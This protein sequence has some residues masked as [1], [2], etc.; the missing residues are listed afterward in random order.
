MCVDPVGFSPLS[1]PSRR[2]MRL[3][4]TLPRRGG[5]CSESRRSP[6]PLGGTGPAARGAA[7]PPAASP[8]WKDPH[9]QQSAPAPTADRVS[10]AL[11]LRLRRRRG[12]G[13]VGS[14]PSRL[15]LSRCGAQRPHPR[16]EGGERRLGVM[17]A[18]NCRSPK[19]DDTN[20]RSPAVCR[21][22]AREGASG[23]RCESR[24][25][26]IRIPPQQADPAS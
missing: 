20:N 11:R 26:Q 24:W 7:T 13:R 18:H 21:A 14:G 10:Q 22:P 3:K 17:S 12:H 6:T 4:N 25:T 23:T 1:A 16:C 8:S 9:A 2:S 15:S 5:R 19:P